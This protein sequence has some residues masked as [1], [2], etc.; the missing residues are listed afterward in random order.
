MLIAWTWCW[1]KRGVRGKQSELKVAIDLVEMVPVEG[2]ITTG[3]ALYC[4]RE[5][6]K[7]VIEAG[8]DYLVIVKGNQPTLY[9]DIELAFARP[10]V[11]EE[12]KFTEDVGRH[13]DRREVRRLWATDALN[14]YLD[15]PGVRQVCKIEREVAR[16][17]KITR[18]LRYAITSLRDQVGA[19][20]LLKYVRGHWRIENRLHYVRDVTMGE[21]NSQ[22]R[23]G[24]APQVMAVL[25]NVVLG[26]LR[27]M[28]V[29]NIAAAIRQISWTS[30]QALKVLGI[31]PS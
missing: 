8:G 21:D 5:Y 4:Q 30:G 6:C 22:V 11:G 15:W 18:D 10:V 23:K 17:G 14:E 16:K 27:L 12:Y 25:R 31:L 19:E 9:E 7:K 13:G 2:N 20:A 3:D 26:I 1:V 24:S 29:P 28:G